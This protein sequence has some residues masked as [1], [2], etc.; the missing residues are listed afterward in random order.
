MQPKIPQKMLWIKNY[1]FMYIPQK[2]R[3]HR[4]SVLFLKSHFLNVSSPT[5]ELWLA[6]PK[7]KK[8]WLTLTGEITKQK[9]DKWSPKSTRL[10]TLVIPIH[11]NH[12]CH[13][14]RML[15]SEKCGVFTPVPH[16]AGEISPKVTADVTASPS[17]PPPPLL[18]SSLR[19]LRQRLSC[20][21]ASWRSSH[22][23]SIF[24]SYSI[25]VAPRLVSCG[26]RLEC[27]HW[28]GWSVGARDGGGGGGGG[29]RCER[30]SERVRSANSCKHL[31]CSNRSDSTHQR[32]LCCV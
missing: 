11:D 28:G 1:I 5:V 13:T 31:R 29:G 3:Q 25:T 15:A 18:L 4:A 16:F 32:A 19:L 9:N 21:S 27:G 10:S 2:N 23:P 7:K 24:Q 12:S 20:T 14:G 30:E 8:T 26:H 6:L 17:L 22:H